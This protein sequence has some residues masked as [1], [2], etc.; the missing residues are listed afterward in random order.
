M[1]MMQPGVH[2][3]RV[4]DVRWNPAHDNFPPQLVIHFETYQPDGP[5]D[6]IAWYLKLG[7]TKDGFSTKLFDFEVKQLALMGWNAEENGYRFEELQDPTTCPFT[8]WNG[9]IEVDLYNGKAQFKW[10]VNEDAP[11]RERMQP[12]DAKAFCDT[13]RAKLAAAGKKV[14]PVRSPVPRPVGALPGGARTID[15]KDIQTSKPLNEG[16]KV[17]FDE[18]P[19]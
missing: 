19:F 4:S 5:P 6:F 18:V 13:L 14:A 15:A 17:N 1:P 9:R 12:Q 16:G 8:S 11:V 10:V 3:A 7:E 2:E